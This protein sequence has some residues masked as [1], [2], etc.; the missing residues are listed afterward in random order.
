M[1]VAPPGI[2][3]GPTASLTPLVSKKNGLYHLPK[4]LVIPIIVSEPP[5][6]FGWQFGC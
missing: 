3:P 2:A 5:A 1:Y 4:N 6:E